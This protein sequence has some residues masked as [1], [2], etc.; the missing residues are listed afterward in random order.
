MK[1]VELLPQFLELVQV[2]RYWNRSS[3]GAARGNSRAAVVHW[4][5]ENLHFMVVTPKSKKVA[6]ADIGS[7]PH[8]D[9]ANPF[10]ALANHFREKSIQVQR[11]VVLLSRPELDL[12]TLTLPP[13]EASELPA[14]VASE[15]E[16]QL[17][18]A[19]EPPA[20]DFYVLPN[21]NTS[22][23][24][25]GT[26][27]ATPAGVQVLAFALPASVQRTLQ[28]Q[29]TGAGF[30]AVAICSRQLSPLGI[31]QRRHVPESTLAVSVHLYASEAELAICRG[32]EPILLR[33]LRINP[34]DPVRV[35]EQI[36]L[37]SQRCLALLPNEVADLPFSWFVYT[38]CE[39]SYQV[40]QALEE[41]EHI[42][43]QP[44]DPLIGWEVEPQDQSAGGMKFASAAN[45]GAAWEFL[46]DKLPVN[47]LAPKKP[48]KAAN[49]MTRWAAMGAAA[50][51]VLAIGV[52]FLLSD[53]SRL[54]DEVQKLEG[55]L[56]NAKKLTAKYQEKAD[57]VATIENWLS[58][59]VDWV[60]EL[61]ELS[62]RLPDGQNATVR[63][64]TASANSSTA[65]IDL[66]VQVA[67][68]E[69]IS[70][71]EGSIRSAKYAVT[72][73]QISQNPESE[74]YPW[75]FETRIVFPVESLSKSRKYESKVKAEATP[76]KDLPVN[77]SPVN[78]LRVNDLQIKDLP[79]TGATLQ[80]DSSSKTEPTAPP[81][82]KEASQ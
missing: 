49:P 27:A 77:D 74:E 20:I 69:T 42:T 14:L 24:S 45:A 2:K 25:E 73:K 15:V 50:A 11:L 1:L 65:V 70:Q 3:S 38:T 23:P 22:Q 19:E 34:D 64:L 59:Q 78:V 76:A 72:S 4:D 44:V 17:G 81:T 55:E 75:Q 41:H 10:V 67:K 40:A 66:A 8:A 31:L 57:Q 71:F 60:D 61:N 56:G 12:L 28:S 47:L 58:D 82:A 32:P 21:S 53:I 62:K 63:R 79:A 48:P 46:N 18:E 9:V 6:L 80:A 5:R 33:S 37:E 16:Q 43:I 35:A 26:Q 39:A 54:N 29:I 68:Q 30:R 7:V 13:S 51:V 52:Y 36:W